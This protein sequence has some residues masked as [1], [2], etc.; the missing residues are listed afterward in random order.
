M[1]RLRT[2]SALL[3]LSTAPAIGCGHHDDAALD[4]VTDN[5][6]LTWE[7]F[8]DATYREPGTGIFIVEGDMP[9]ADEARLRDYYNRHVQQGA[10]VVNLVDGV[11]DAWDP[12][13][14]LDLTYCVDRGSLGQ[15]YQRVVD[16]LD[17]AA[18]DWE[19]VAGVD[20]VHVT[21]L[22]DRCGPRT[23]GVVFDVRQV[24]GQPYRARAFFPSSR[25]A[26]RN[27]LI[28]TSIYPSV[29]D[30]NEP[31]TLRGIMRHEFGHALGFRHEHTRPET[32]ACYEDDNWRPLTAYD[33]ES[34]MHYDNSR[35]P[36]TKTGDHVITAHDAEGAESLYPIG[37]PVCQPQG[38]S[39]ASH[40]DCC[41]GTCRKKRG[42]ETC[43]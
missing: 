1:N 34:V 27:I 41:S 28:N 35:C 22:D 38:A 19:A 11:D 39:C 20:F 29:D 2:L 43:E 33:A 18:A 10:L 21:S 40:D 6:A 5:Q 36:G 9:I 26:D 31:A 24:E 12:A 15:N 8:R 13:Q 3:A 42:T 30:P 23:R 14:A 37:G 32:G 25:R 17:G 4:L 7:Q 16:A